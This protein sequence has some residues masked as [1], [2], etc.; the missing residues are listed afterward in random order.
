MR[1][2]RL[3]TSISTEITSLE[4]QKQDLK[5]DIDDFYVQLT[6]TNVSQE[7]RDKVR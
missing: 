5:Y 3:F 6:A 7:H 2:E 1:V 4:K